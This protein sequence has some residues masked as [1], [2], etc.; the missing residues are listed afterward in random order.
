MPLLKTFLN[1]IS[2]PLTSVGGSTAEQSHVWKTSG[3]ENKVTHSLS[4][5]REVVCGTRVPIVEM[6]PNQTGLAIT[7]KVK[8]GWGQGG[9][10]GGGWSVSYNATKS[11]TQPRWTCNHKQTKKKKLRPRIN[12]SASFL[13]TYRFTGKR[14]WSSVDS[15]WTL[16]G[17]TDRRDIL[18]HLY[19]NDNINIQFC[20]ILVNS[21]FLK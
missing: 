9:R 11:C 2:T 6:N 16:T 5:E 8:R 20:C 12:S 17:E 3:S 10:G 18:S 19:S 4:S 15:E 21:L 14:K 7:D 1:L 13:L